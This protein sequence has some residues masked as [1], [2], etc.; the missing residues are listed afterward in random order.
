M[1]KISVSELEQLLTLIKR[2]SQDVHVVL[3]E[4]AQC[5]NIQFQNIDNQITN[6]SLYD[7]GTQLFARVTATENL[8]QVLGRLKA[9]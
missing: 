3:R 8:T 6:V 1:I 5:L 4:D 2:T 9:K 7:E